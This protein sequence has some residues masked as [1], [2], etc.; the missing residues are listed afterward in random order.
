MQ[1]LNFR[2]YNPLNNASLTQNRFINQANL[3]ASP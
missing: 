3:F 2:F 1:D